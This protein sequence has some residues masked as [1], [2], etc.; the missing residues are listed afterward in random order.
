MGIKLIIANLNILN[1]IFDCNSYINDLAINFSNPKTQI[2][3][4][5][6][7][8][9]DH[10]MFFI[11]M[12]F[13]LKIIFF[14]QSLLSSTKHTYIN[15]RA[16][17]PHNHNLEEVKAF[18]LYYAEEGI[19]NKFKNAT[20]LEF[21]WTILP[22]VILVLMAIPSFILLYAMEEGEWPMFNICAIGNQWY[23][24]YEYMDF[25]IVKYYKIFVQNLV[26]LQVERNH[27]YI[28][29]RD[30]AIFRESN[31]K[32]GLN[33]NNTTLNKILDIYNT[34]IIH[35]PFNTFNIKWD[36]NLLP[37]QYLRN[38][39]L[40]FSAIKTSSDFIE[41]NN[42]FVGHL[43]YAIF[44][45][46]NLFYKFFYYTLFSS[47]TYS[48]IE[49]LITEDT[50]IIDCQ[51]IPESDLPKGY[52]RLLCTDQ[53]LVL[54]TETTIRV[55]VTS[56]DVIHSW[57]LPSFGIK[58]DGI[59]GRINQ[60]LLNT[61]FFGTVWGQCSELCGINHGFMP[62]ELRTIGLTE[63]KEYMNIM[64]FNSV[65]D[66]NKTFLK[67]HTY[68]DVALNYTRKSIFS[69]WWDFVVDRGLE[70]YEQ[71]WA[72]MALREQFLESLKTEN[73]DKSVDD[74]I[75][76]GLAG[77]MLEDRFLYITFF[78]I[79]EEEMVETD[80]P[81]KPSAKIIIPS[82]PE[83]RDWA[84]KF[85]LDDIFRILEQKDSN[86][87][88]DPII[89]IHDEIKQRCIRWDNTDILAAIRCKRLEEL[90][91]GLPV[92]SIQPWEPILE[93][94]RE[95]NKE[96]TK[97]LENIKSII[98]KNDNNSNIEHF[99]KMNKRLM[100]NLKMIKQRLKN[101]SDNESIV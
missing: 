101:D 97:N 45:T 32:K 80:V 63:F 73:I 72:R 12:I 96:L 38:D 19:N 71:F 47:N 44:Y 21:V 16:N 43:N 69:F 41:E 84:K 88:K 94:F 48:D 10:L 5:I 49:N 36:T 65:E 26:Q 11:L 39:T 81:F 14:S 3:I 42:V 60:L 91:A 27:N 59:P 4:G 35:K 29:S 55:L 30:V 15:R 37:M 68:S 74:L 9:H 83:I 13:I 7:E 58:M 90:Y 62:I 2:M 23:W 25:D 95:K 53:V 46:L 99:R 31:L 54:P 89:N 40:K 92:S 8:L 24:T 56:N 93:Y 51:I 18:N 76:Y 34:D 22:A 67:S 20:L 86:I 87:I 61:P 28:I 70:T 17:D 1:N 64:I 52:P 33:F 66:L 79:E 75:R 6:M 98:N 85:I 77:G 100:E 50:I 57:S 78:G 82:S